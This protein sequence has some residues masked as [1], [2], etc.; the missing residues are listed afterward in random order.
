MT[1]ES[2]EPVELGKA[3][4]A[5]EFVEQNSPEEVDE[6]FTPAVAPYVEFDE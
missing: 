3:E 1:N 4:T 2:F 5:I 6:K